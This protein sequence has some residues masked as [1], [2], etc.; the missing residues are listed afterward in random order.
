MDT[1][2]VTRRSFLRVSA[3]AGGGMLGAT[4][5][6]LPPVGYAVYHFHHGSEELLVVLR[7]RPTLRTP[8]GDRAIAQWTRAGW[9]S[10][11]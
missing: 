4:V 11:A 2:Q 3:V 5:D 7:G 10:S 9:A 8:A 1:L 6:E